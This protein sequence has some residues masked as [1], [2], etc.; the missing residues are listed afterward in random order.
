MSTST[1]SAYFSFPKTRQSLHMNSQIT[2]GG[3]KRE[4]S[5]A[6]TT[7]EPQNGRRLQVQILLETETWRRQ[8]SLLVTYKRFKMIDSQLSAQRRAMMRNIP[9][10]DQG[11]QK[12]S[13]YIVPCFLLVEVS[14]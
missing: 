8:W 11:L 13:T 3:E 12:T 4:R 10:E 14:V 5:A 2:G 6:E 1:A 9:D 7:T